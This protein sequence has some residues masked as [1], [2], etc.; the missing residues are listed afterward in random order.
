MDKKVYEVVTN[1]LAHAKRS[2]VVSEEKVI[3]ERKTYTIEE[4]KNRI[5]RRQTQIAILEAANSVD[6]DL[7]ND[8]VSATG[9][10]PDKVDPAPEP[11]KEDPV[12]EENELSSRD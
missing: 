1:S 10:D 7:I 8:I 2:V 12:D 9:L 4:L 3:V 6:N 11:P 5:E